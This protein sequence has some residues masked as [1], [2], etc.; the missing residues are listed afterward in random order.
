MKLWIDGTY[1]G[2]EWDRDSAGALIHSQPMTADN[3]ILMVEYKDDK[4]LP[5]AHF[6]WDR[7]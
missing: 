1:I 4:A 5:L 7:Q 2:N 6:R 3:Y